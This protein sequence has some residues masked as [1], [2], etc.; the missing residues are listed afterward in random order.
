[1]YDARARWRVR[2][3]ASRPTPAGKH[4]LQRIAVGLLETIRQHQA[5]LGLAGAAI[6]IAAVW[7]GGRRHTAAM[8][9]LMAELEVTKRN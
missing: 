9:K 4:N 2:S 8:A 1:M 5:M 7:I 6:I 3:S